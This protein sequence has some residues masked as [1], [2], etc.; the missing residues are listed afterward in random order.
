MVATQVRIIQYLWKMLGCSGE[1]IPPP[2][3]FPPVWL[4]FVNPVGNATCG[5]L[6]GFFFW[7]ARFLLSFLENKILNFQSDQGRY[8]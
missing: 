2:P 8:R 6:R 7:V 5:S 4:G 1:G 3:N